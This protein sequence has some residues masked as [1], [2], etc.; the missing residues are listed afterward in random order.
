MS[1]PAAVRAA[2]A[3]ALRSDA[4]LRGLLNGV[5]AGPAV[6]SSPPFAEVSETLAADW[7]TKDTRGR[8]VRVAVMLRDAAETP[9]RLGAIAALAERAIEA[10]P[11]EIAGWRVA[12]IAFLRSRTTGDGPGKWL[13]VLEYRVRVLEAD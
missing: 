7:G 8:E 13:C 12:S 5:F 10:M 1:G 11:R 9:A 4:E 6:R 3:D 2:V